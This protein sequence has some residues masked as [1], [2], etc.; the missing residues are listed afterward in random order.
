[1]GYASK[2]GRARVNARNPQAA[3]ICDRCGFVFQRTSLRFQYDWRGT[4]IQNLYQLVCNACYD[5]PQEQLRA[6]VVPADPIPIINP[7]PQDYVSASEDRRQISGANT[8]DPATGI[9]VIAGATRTT[10]TNDTRVVQETGAPDGS[11]NVLPG[12]DLNAPG[13]GNPGLPYD[14]TSVPQ[15][16][17]LIVPVPLDPG[18]FMTSLAAWASLLPAAPGLPGSWFIDGIWIARSPGPYA[19]Q[20][21]YGSGQVQTVLNFSVPGL[22]ANPPSGGGLYLPQSMLAFAAGGSFMPSPTLTV[23]QVAYMMDAWA[24]SA[25]WTPSTPVYFDGNYDGQGGG[26]IAVPA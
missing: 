24:Q 22:A 11:L 26:F 3:G 10:Q 7:R 4:T 20:S 12:T 19:T 25:S 13:N 17:P 23:Q 21:L 8:V 18:A 2:L 6:I 5:T 1:M 16:G 9:P 15:T 14:F